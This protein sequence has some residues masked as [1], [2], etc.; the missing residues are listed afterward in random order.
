MWEETNY[1]WVV[2]ITTLRKEGVFWVLAYALK[3]WFGWLQALSTFLFICEI[4]AEMFGLV[5]WQQMFDLPRSK[6]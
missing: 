2:F 1:L 4:L 5:F 6:A 3:Y